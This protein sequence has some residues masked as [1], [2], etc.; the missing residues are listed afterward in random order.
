[1]SMIVPGDEVGNFKEEVALQPQVGLEAGAVQDAGRGMESAVLK[2]DPDILSGSEME[3]AAGRGAVARPQQVEAAAVT[4]VNG[5]SEAELGRRAGITAQ[6]TEKAVAVGAPDEPKTVAAEAD[7]SKGVGVGAVESESAP[8]TRIG[9]IFGSVGKFEDG[10]GVLKQLNR[11]DQELDALGREY[12][13]GFAAIN[14]SETLQQTWQE[15]RERAKQLYNEYLESAPQG[16]VA[17]LF[18]ESYNEHLAEQERL[19]SGAAARQ[20]QTEEQ[21]DISFGTE[22]ALKRLQYRSRNVAE[23][24]KYTEKAYRQAREEAYLSGI[25]NPEQIT[26][27]AARRLVPGIEGMVD[28]LA[29]SGRF[30]EAYRYLEAVEKK[31]G[32][33]EVGVIREGIEAQE[34]TTKIRAFARERNYAQ[35]AAYIEGLPTER[36]EL[37]ELTLTLQQRSAE[38][39]GAERKARALEMARAE[40]ERSGALKP[41]VLVDQE[42]VK[43]DAEDYRQ[44]LARS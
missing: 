1:M 4:G 34:V 38:Q 16:K 2:P 15:Y 19:Y 25:K 13:Q 26:E 9:T 39:A 5:M 27:F 37:A 35:L 17:E 41:Y 36:R 21:K 28:G 8:D 40:Y 10:V 29:A 33:Q 32:A 11:Y 30:Q 42:R 43:L 24:I 14:D 31:I 12:T 23:S 18:Q 7:I 20:R 6:R 3:T 22:I 44:L